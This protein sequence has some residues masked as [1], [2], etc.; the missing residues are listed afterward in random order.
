V[1]E[2]VNAYKIWSK[3]VEKK[4]LVKKIKC[5]YELFKLS[6]HIVINIP[7]FSRRIFLSTRQSCR[8][9]NNVHT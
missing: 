3:S 1:D 6:C 4:K 5:T 2:T 7:K 9:V 8:I